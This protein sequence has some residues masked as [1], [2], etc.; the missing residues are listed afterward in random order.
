[1]QDSLE[2]DAAIDT[3]LCCFLAGSAF[4][5]HQF[6]HIPSQLR[7]AIETK[8]IFLKLSICR[9]YHYLF[10]MGI[11]SLHFLLLLCRLKLVFRGRFSI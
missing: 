4:P 1:M 9:Q 5:Y 6:A 3:Y 2:T 8:K 7:G 10:N 11:V